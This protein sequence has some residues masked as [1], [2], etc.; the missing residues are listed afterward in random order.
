MDVLDAQ[1]KQLG[2]KIDDTV[3]NENYCKSFAL[4]VFKMAD[5]EG[6]FTKNYNISFKSLQIAGVK[7]TSKQNHKIE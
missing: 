5:D 3:A 7:Q 4:R 6:K 1:K 2:S